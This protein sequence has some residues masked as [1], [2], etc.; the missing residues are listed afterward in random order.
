[1]KIQ[2]I[3][4]IRTYL[5]GGTIMQYP[6]QTINQLKPLIQGFRKKAGLTQAAIA[7]K[8]GVSQQSYAQM[9]SNLATTSVERLY[10]ILRLLNV[11]LHLT[12]GAEPSQPIASVAKAALKKNGPARSKGVPLNKD[13]SRAGADQSRTSKLK[14]KSAIGPAPTKMSKRSDTSKW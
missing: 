3:N 8:I 9:E 4:C 6:L 2:S 14:T 10:T 7:E 12:E 1:M 5:S 13:A 11:Q